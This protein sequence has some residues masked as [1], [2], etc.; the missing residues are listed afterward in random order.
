MTSALIAKEIYS[1]NRA[2][3]TVSEFLIKN[4]LV[5]AHELLLMY[6]CDGVFS[7][8]GEWLANWESVKRWLS[9]M[10]K[11]QDIKSFINTIETILAN[12]ARL[13]ADGW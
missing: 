9:P 5:V 8:K 12:I 11:K 1:A 13:R 6:H 7:S 2:R 10:A 4:R 3:Q